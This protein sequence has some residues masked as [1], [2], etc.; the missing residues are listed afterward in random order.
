MYIMQ[1][2]TIKKIKKFEIK[3]SLGRVNNDFSICK[4]IV[5]YTLNGSVSE[6]NLSLSVLEDYIYSD[7]NLK[8][9]DEIT[10][11]KKSYCQY[12]DYYEFVL[13]ET[14]NF[15]VI[16]IKPIS[17]SGNHKYFSA[18]LINKERDIHVI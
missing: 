10:E 14:K 7:A 8:V 6:K 9:G 16:D 11:V 15:V 18:K 4:R 1:V 12:F 5:K 13:I 3:I 17:F 2:E